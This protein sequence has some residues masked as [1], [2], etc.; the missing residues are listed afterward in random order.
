MTEPDLH[1]LP[2]VPPIDPAFAARV[3]SRARA[4]LRD[5]GLLPRE[6]AVPALLLLAGVFSA[7]TS[8]ELFIRLWG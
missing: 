2:A 4:R 5:R 6:R 8:I 3:Q 7:A 1:E